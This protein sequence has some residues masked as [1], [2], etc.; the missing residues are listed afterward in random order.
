MYY[1]NYIMLYYYYYIIIYLGFFWFF[2]TPILGYNVLLQLQEESHNL[3]KWA[4]F[5]R[6]SRKHLTAQ[7]TLFHS[8]WS[9]TDFWIPP[10]CPPHL[11]WGCVA[12][13]GMNP[14]R[15]L[16]GNSICFAVLLHSS[17]C[18]SIKHEC[19]QH[20]FLEVKNTW[21]KIQSLSPAVFLTLRFLGPQVAGYDS[22]PVPP[23]TC[24]CHGSL[25][26]DGQQR[27]AITSPHG[28]QPPAPSPAHI[29]ALLSVQTPEKLWSSPPHR[30][31]WLQRSFSSSFPASICWR[32]EA[33]RDFWDSGGTG[34]MHL[35]GPDT[36][37][38]STPPWISIGGFIL[39]AGLSRI[40]PIQMA[41][42]LEVSLLVAALWPLCWTRVSCPLKR[43]RLATSNSSATQTGQECR[44]NKAEVACGQLPVW[45]W[46]EVGGRL[47]YKWYTP[48]SKA[49]IFFCWN[50]D[51][52]A[53]KRMN[54]W[55]KTASC[56]CLIDNSPFAASWET[57]LCLLRN[58]VQFARICIT[59]Y[60][61]LLNPI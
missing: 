26:N 18:L 20:V 11:L 27:P 14:S 53:L 13:R 8:L 28:F 34:K 39:L 15:I 4:G 12:E 3:K 61:A 5:R 54:I 43:R 1:L 35:A 50:L 57:E 49:S 36:P 44:V 45:K 60:I 52:Q 21:S 19:V 16:P 37:S 2:K 59:M 10:L 30:K 6:H 48:N 9:W 42:L 51:Y 40:G 25:L 29:K 58:L 41:G 55:R 24:H 31:L 33:A 32:E 47:I 46:H 7:D 23:C 17:K 56:R 22:T 38:P